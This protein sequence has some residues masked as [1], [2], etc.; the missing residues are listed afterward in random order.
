M[1]KSE[2]FA[3]GKEKARAAREKNQL[4]G[5]SI[6]TPPKR[7]SN[8]NGPNADD[9]DDEYLEEHARPKWSQKQRD[10][11]CTVDLAAVA[12]YSADDGVH[13]QPFSILVPIALEKSVVV[14]GDGGRHDVETRARGVEE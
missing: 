4:S 7:R 12:G 1:V 11:E 3:I 6:L 8:T 5:E 2:N 13:A 10:G 9:D 14:D